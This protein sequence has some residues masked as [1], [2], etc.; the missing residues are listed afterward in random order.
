VSPCSFKEE[1]RPLL[2][3][4]AGVAPAAMLLLLLLL[5]A[6]VATGHLLPKPALLLSSSARA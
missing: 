2:L 4:P 1:A 5:E 3:L 6:A